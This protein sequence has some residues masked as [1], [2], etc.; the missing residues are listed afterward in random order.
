MGMHAIG[1][2]IIYTSLVSR[3]LSAFL[4]AG[5]KQERAWY[6]KSHDKCWHNGVVL[7]LLQRVDF[8]PA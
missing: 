7:A 8:K 6:L 3:P 5:K 4:L 2:C 1:Q